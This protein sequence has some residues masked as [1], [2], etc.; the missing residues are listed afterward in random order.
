MLE[1]YPRD[2]RASSGSVFGKAASFVGKGEFVR[3]NDNGLKLP[4]KEFT[5]MFWVKPEGGQYRYTPIIGK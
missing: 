1:R 4:S 3:L 5:L 2:V